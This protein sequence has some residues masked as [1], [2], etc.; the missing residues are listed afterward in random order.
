[1]KA[2]KTTMYSVR[3]SETLEGHDPSRTNSISGPFK[4]LKEAQDDME[5]SYQ[6]ICEVR[7][8]GNLNEDEYYMEKDGRHILMDD[9][10]GNIWEAEIFEQRF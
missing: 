6:F 3:Y 7:F 2:A 1:M 8:W 4:S 9:G 5:A 10:N